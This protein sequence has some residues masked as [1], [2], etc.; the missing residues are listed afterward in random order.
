M[1]LLDILYAL[2]PDI[3]NSEPQMAIAPLIVAAII[4]TAIA[5]GSAGAQAAVNKKANR[6]QAD[7]EADKQRK[8]DAKAAQENAFY[9]MEYYR[10]PMR[11]AEGANALK[12]IREYN[13]RLTDIQHN[14]NVITGGTHEQVIAQQ[15]KAM[16]AYSNAVSNIRADHEK[17]RRAIGQNWLRAQ[18]NQFQRQMNAD[19]AQQAIRMQGYE[20]LNTNIQNF[21]NVAQTAVSGAMGNAESPT[22]YNPQANSGTSGMAGGNFANTSAKFYDKSKPKTVADPKTGLRYTSYLQ[23]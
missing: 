6:K 2:S 5:A 23:S 13:Q 22:T 12:Q 14:R 17:T 7:Y 18:D 4:S 10:D 21:A 15:D 11:T 19:D 8:I 9:R 3:V 1:I 16:Q 20:N